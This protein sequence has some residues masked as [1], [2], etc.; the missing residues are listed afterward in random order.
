MLAMDSGVIALERA[1]QLA[2]SGQVRSVA[3]IRAQLKT[4]GY[5]LYVFEGRTLLRQLRALISEA[6]RT[7]SQTRPGGDLNA[8][9]DL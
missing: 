6:E 2:Q 9:N 4:E 5:D 3:E 1:F 7:R 8:S